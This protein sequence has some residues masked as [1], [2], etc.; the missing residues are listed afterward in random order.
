MGYLSLDPVKSPNLCQA[1]SQNK[2][3]SRTSCCRLAHPPPQTGNG[4]QPESEGGNRGP[5]EASDTKLQ[6]DFIANQD[7]LR[8]WMVSKCQEGHSQ[9]SASQKRFMAHLRRCTHCTPRKPSGWDGGGDKLQPSTGG[10]Y[11]LLRT[12]SFELLKTGMGAKH[13]PKQVCAFVEYT[14]T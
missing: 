11:A 12:W 7:F 13:R 6:A 2:R 10:D 9:R 5:R 14:K 8:F 3:L 1:G 4:G